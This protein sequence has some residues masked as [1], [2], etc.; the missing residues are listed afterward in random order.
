MTIQADDVGTV[1]I[2]GKLAI[3]TKRRA[4]TKI[5]FSSNS[6]LIAVNVLDDGLM[7][8]GFIGFIAETTSGIVTD[9]S[10]KCVAYSPPNK[11]AQLDFDDSSWPNAHPYVMNNFNIMM[12]LFFTPF[13]NAEWW[14]KAEQMSIVSMRMSQIYCRKHLQPTLTIG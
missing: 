5:S 2:D 8:I 6:R 7:E 3:T 12:S 4:Q 14:I 9:E 10:W 13:K 11:W 1:Y